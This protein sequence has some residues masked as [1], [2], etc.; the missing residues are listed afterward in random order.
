[1]SLEKWEKIVDCMSRPQIFWCRMGSSILLFAVLHMQRVYISRK[2]TGDRAECR[3]AM[4]VMME[5]DYE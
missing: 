4:S 2:T 1:V 3:F 5:D